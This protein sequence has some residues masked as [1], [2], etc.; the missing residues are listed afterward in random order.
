[1]SFFQGKNV[2]VTGATGLVG[3]NLLNRLLDTGAVIR[4]TVH[5]RPAVVKD[6]RIAYIP[7]DLTRRE[8]CERAVSGIDY[9]FHC[10]ASTSGAAVIAGNPLVHVTPNV[11]MNAQLLEEAYH[12]KVKKFLWLSSSTGYPPTGYR[13]VKE[14]EML[15]G[16]PYDK[17]FGV[18]WMKRYTE[19]L[20]RM[21]AQKLN[22]PMPT[23]V[24]RPTNIYGEYDDFRF[25][26]SHVFAALVRRVVERHDPLE[27]WGDG[28]DVRDLIYVQDFI[29]AMLLAMELVKRY[30]AF[31]I[32]SGRGITVKDLLA[33]MLEIDGFSSARVFYDPSKPT[34]IPVR[35][36]DVS[37]AQK[38][39]GFRPV[40][41]IR[42]GITNT[43]RWYRDHPV[44]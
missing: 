14:E 8:D 4:A 2:L 1:M 11:V 40:T 21:Y 6:P 36:V 41:G 24:L 32:G 33:Q 10:A 18:G 16:D 37:R 20:C 28:E 29:T 30:A 3:V 22:P 42:T 23:V 43:L 19:T 35:L 13:P 5:D 27:V 15:D 12:A 17:Y 31:N 38:E 26:T 44:R 7:C 9:V 25:E 34:M 39:L